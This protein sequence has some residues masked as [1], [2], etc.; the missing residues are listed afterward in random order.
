MQRVHVAL[1]T[2]SRRA[3]AGYATSERDAKRARRAEANQKKYS[4]PVLLAA[5]FHTF[6]GGIIPKQ[7]QRRGYQLWATSSCTSGAE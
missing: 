5:D 1:L 2:R 4:N 7:E 6:T 3:G